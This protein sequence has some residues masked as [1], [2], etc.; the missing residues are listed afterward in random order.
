MQSQVHVDLTVLTP[1]SETLQNSELTV[2]KGDST[3]VFAIIPSKY[4]I[5]LP[6]ADSY[7]ISVA[8]MGYSP[9]SLQTHF[10]S[11]TA[12][13]VVLQPKTFELGEVVVTGQAA[14]KITATGE[15]FQLSQK[16]K[17]S[18]DPYK[19]LSEIPLLDVD[20]VN[21]RV[22][23]NAGE[24]ML[25]LIDGKLQNSGIQPID[26]KF[27][28]RVEISEVVSARFLKM[29]VSKI[30]NIRLRKD[31]LLYVYTDLRSRH[32][33]P[34]REG[35]GGANFEVGRK[36]FALSGSAFYSYLHHDKSDFAQSEASADVSRFV[37]GE[38]IMNNHSWKGSLMMKWIPWETDYISA[39]V[40]GQLLS[41]TAHSH[42]E[43]QYVG[44]TS[45]PLNADYVSDTP[46]KGFLLGLYHEHTFKNTS[47]LTTYFLYNLSNSSIDQRLSEQYNNEEHVTPVNYDT[48]RNQ[49]ILSID[50]DTQDQPY[51][52]INLGN[53]FEYTADRDKDLLVGTSLP[54]YTHLWSNYTYA[55]YTNS[56]NK[57]FYMASV[58]LENLGVEILNH[59]N[60]CWRPRVSTSLSWKLPRRQS[61]RI[62]YNLDNTLPS[63]SS[64]NTLNTS[65][66][67]ML[68]V[69]GNPYLVP[70]QSHLVGMNYNVD[71]KRFRM[72]FAATHY[73][74]SDI[75][76]PYI[77][78]NG[79]TQ[80]Q[81][82]RNNGT[83]KETEIAGNVRYSGNKII[84]FAAA[85]HTWKSFNGQPTKGVVGLNGYVRWDFS[86]FFI[87]S[88]IGWQ[89]REYTP[90]STIKYESPLEAHVQIAWQAT[91]H[92]Y[93]SLGLPY[94]WGVKKQ[95]TT[96]DQEAYKSWQHDRFKGM[97]LRPWLL[98]SWTL[99][100]NAKEA[101][102]DKLSNL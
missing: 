20:V 47:T 92:L 79:E 50:F 28:D 5:T 87:Y 83:Y 40:K 68:R 45:Y 39:V 52:D 27:I 96:I 60:V 56:W 23:T 58:G 98:I 25:I 10:S 71:L 89:N 13:V 31:R 57:L 19:A 49:Y 1:T 75:V 62:F 16:A 97:S 59:S 78:S 32:D 7:E 65:T 93:M 14:R 100:K 81:S 86:N 21:Q 76:E 61:L 84:V 43:G 48:R 64:L 77:Y 55:G 80:I 54:V 82:F 2:G 42:T 101:I 90:I 37:A 29:G 44:K 24:S 69:E 17:K 46:D 9:C 67:P 35:F 36:T 4:Q 26:P 34:L 102:P 63:S 73:R 66:N 91:K 94:F 18:G 74:K 38:N 15:I 8:H 70:E 95:T 12:L 53:Q 51:G 85:T 22:R 41:N 72:S 6:S 3:V 88:K 11:D 99:R 33:I 30:L